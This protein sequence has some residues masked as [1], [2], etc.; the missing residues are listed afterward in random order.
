MDRTEEQQAA[1]LESLTQALLEA[2][3]P[4]A[5]PPNRY[6]AQA[7]QG[8]VRQREGAGRYAFHKTNT[9]TETNTDE[10]QHH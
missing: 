5:E 6:A 1:A 8:L 2:I 9:T 10:H 3:G 4:N 7:R